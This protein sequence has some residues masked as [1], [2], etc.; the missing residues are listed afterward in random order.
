MFGGVGDCEGGGTTTVG[1]ESEELLFPTNPRQSGS[2]KHGG[3]DLLLDEGLE[4]YEVSL[5][6]KEHS[7]GHI[8]NL[9]TRHPNTPPHQ[10]NSN[11][12]DYERTYDILV[13]LCF[14]IGRTSRAK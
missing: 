9:Y 11:S 7:L 6:S 10:S 4:R 8:R 14:Q 13:I 3:K 1:E 2:L 12:T 5:D